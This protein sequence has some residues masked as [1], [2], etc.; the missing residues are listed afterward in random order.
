MQA[1][2]LKP[3]NAHTYTA[4]G[5]VHALM[6]NLEDAITYFHKSLGINRDCIVTSTILKTCIED[7]MDEDNIIESIC[8]KSDNSIKSSKLNK[9]ASKL[10]TIEESPHK[11]NAVKLKFDDFSGV[12]PSTT[13]NMDSNLIMDLSMDL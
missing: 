9:T 6:G 10:P 8:S 1:L 2:L 7:L 12:S 5:F 11:Y 13:D 3:K 4:I